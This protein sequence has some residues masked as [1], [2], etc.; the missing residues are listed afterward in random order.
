MNT[1]KFSLE[2]LTGNHK[3]KA[4]KDKKAA[5]TPATA[6]KRKKTTVELLLELRKYKWDFDAMQSGR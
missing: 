1:T 2:Q 3:P 4:A 5:K 6:K